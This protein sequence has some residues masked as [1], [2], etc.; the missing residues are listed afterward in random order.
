M[1]RFI[2]LVGLSVCAIFLLSGCGGR[3]GLNCDVSYDVDRSE[4]SEQ[5]SEEV[6]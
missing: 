5:L 6:K 1:M 2:R 4:E 3:L